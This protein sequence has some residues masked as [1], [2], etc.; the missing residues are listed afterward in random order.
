MAIAPINNEAF[1]RE[2]DEEVR[3]DTALRFWR[4]WG[5]VAIAAAVVAL[6]AFGGWLW[7]SASRTKAAGV[8]GET[9]SVALADL[10][11]GKPNSAQSKLTPLITS[12]VEGHRIAARMTLADIKLSKGDTK[13]A[14]A[15]F[16]AM[17]N[18]ASLAQPYRDLATVREVATMFD[19]LPPAQVVA[20]LKPL[21]VAG[22]AWFGSAGEMTAIAQLRL[23]QP[24]A[25]GATLQA[26]AKDE[27][28]P[29]SIRSRV[30]QLAGTLGIDVVPAGA[31]A[32]S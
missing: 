19:T 26:L 5:R 32:G 22:T 3:R 17:A 10:G 29:E 9:V 11:E 1:L 4:R 21:A 16:A 23:N 6:L 7:W 30:V 2:V 24:K 13:G 18:D 12:S 14:A 27:T 31:K 20:R 28:V 15:D 25:A 8:E